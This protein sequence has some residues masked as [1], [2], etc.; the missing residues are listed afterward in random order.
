MRTGPGG[1]NPGRREPSPEAEVL[2]NARG[3]EAR[4]PRNVPDVSWERGH[5]ARACLGEPPPLPG[6]KPTLPVGD[7]QRRRSSVT[8]TTPTDCPESM[9]R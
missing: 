5:P 3:L 2:R 8:G 6:W 1:T 4:A 7:G 9:S